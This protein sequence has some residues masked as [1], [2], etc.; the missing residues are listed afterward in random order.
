VAGRQEVG[1]GVQ[2]GIGDWQ[3]QLESNKHDFA[4]ALV[5]HPEFVAP[6]G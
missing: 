4:L 2:A 6:T 5:R 1:R 3:A